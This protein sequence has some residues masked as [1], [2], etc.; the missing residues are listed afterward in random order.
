MLEMYVHVHQH[1][2][3]RVVQHVSLLPTVSQS[4]IFHILLAVCASPCQNSGACTAP[5]TCT[6]TSSWTGTICT[7][8][9]T[10][11]VQEQPR[12]ST[13]FSFQR[14][15]RHPA[16]MVVPAAL[17]ILVHAPHSGV[18]WHA[19]HVCIPSLL[20]KEY[21]FEL[22]YL[23]FLAV[24]SPTCSNGGTCNAGNV[25]ACPS[26]WTGSRCTTRKW[27]VGN[28]IISTS[29]FSLQRSVPL[30]VQTEALVMLE[31][32]AHVYRHGLAHDVQQYVSDQSKKRLFRHQFTLSSGL[33][34]CMFE[35]RYMSCWQYLHL[36]VNVDWFTMHDPL[37]FLEKAT[38][39]IFKFQCSSLAVCPSGCFNGG[40]CSSPGVCT[41]AAFWGGSTCTTRM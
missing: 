35:R 5:N 38:T 23:R 16:K 28:T 40:W 3:A 31:T 34:S 12:F 21:S 25:C 19:Q 1:G 20:V 8:R 29:I 41:C 24:C 18:V 11:A 36:S 27:L 33:Y 17:P 6:C 37:V 15:V 13:V 39:F 2:L 7:I 32:H 26:T 30:Y 4:V 22:K 10:V 9:K 14:S